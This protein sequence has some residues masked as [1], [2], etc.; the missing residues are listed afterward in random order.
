VELLVTDS[1]STLSESQLILA[2]TEPTAP[3][4]TS[5]FVAE[6]S[7]QKTPEPMQVVDEVPLMVAVVPAQDEKSTPSSKKILVNEEKATALNDE[8]QPFATVLESIT[9][10]VTYASEVLLMAADSD[11]SPSK[12]TPPNEQ[13]QTVLG[14]E[15]PIISMGLESTA[16]GYI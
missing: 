7:I 11:D 5:A 1:K 12:E 4:V 16:Q 10:E 9:P 15:S 13:K 2:E 14:N 3:E 6:T 8:S